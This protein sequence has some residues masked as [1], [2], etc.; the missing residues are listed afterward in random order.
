M[1]E[2]GDHDDRQKP[3]ERPEETGLI[4]LH[5]EPITGLR[6][7][8]MSVK[9]TETAAVAIADP[10]Q[11]VAATT[12]VERATTPSSTAGTARQSRASISDGST[13]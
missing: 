12:G 7:T 9:T 13:Q 10:T 2:A 8:V 6:L 4:R 5:I 11:A 3:R 1:H